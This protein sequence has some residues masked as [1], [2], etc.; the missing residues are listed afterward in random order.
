MAERP[1]GPTFNAK[2][3]SDKALAFTPFSANITRSDGQQELKGRRRDAAARSDG[4]ARRRPLLLGGKDIAAA[5]GRPGANEQKNPSCPDNSQ[6]GVATVSAGSGPSPLK[7]D[8]K[9]YLAGR[10]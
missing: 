3:A 7:I 5:A 2:P 8:G 9:V 1:F 6:I 10:L 4:E